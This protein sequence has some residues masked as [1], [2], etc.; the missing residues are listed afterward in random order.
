MAFFEDDKKGT[1]LAKTLVLLKASS[2]DPMKIHK[3]TDLPFYWLKDM[4]AGK[5]KNPS[6][7]RIQ[8]L[9]EYLSN[10]SLKV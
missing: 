4:K 10:Q 7:N 8:H 1:L 2:E 5:T 6:V 3:A 9:Y